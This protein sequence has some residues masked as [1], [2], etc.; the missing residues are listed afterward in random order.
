M[1]VVFSPAEA[2]GYR[3]HAALLGVG[4]ET[5]VRAGENRGRRLGHEFVVLGTVAGA[6]LRDEGGY[7][8][9]GRLPAAAVAPEKAGALAVWVTK[10]DAMEPVQAAGGFLDR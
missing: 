8:Y 7:T 3:V 4:I 5:R 6:L 1:R 10:G 9:R 2:A